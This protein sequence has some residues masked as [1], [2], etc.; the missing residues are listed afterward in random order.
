MPRTRSTP[1]LL[2]LVLGV[3]I[4]VEMVAVVVAVFTISIV[5][6]EVDVTRAIQAIEAQ[7]SLTLGAVLGFIA[8][9]A[10]TRGAPD[11]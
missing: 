3:A 11:D 10:H 8:G 7:M 2:V 1:E 6:P 4:A 5:R 9:R